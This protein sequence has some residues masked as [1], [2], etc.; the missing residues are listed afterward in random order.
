MFVV[1]LLLL[2][3]PHSLHTVSNSVCVQHPFHVFV[4]KAEAGD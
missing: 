2:F 4:I 3:F 1:L